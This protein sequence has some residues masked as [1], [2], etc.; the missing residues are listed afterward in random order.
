MQ[1]E[2]KEFAIRDLKPGMYISQVLEQSGKLKIRT[3]GLV[4]TDKAIA[5]LSDQGVIKVLVDLSKS[6]L[7]KKAESEEKSKP[8][9]AP[10]EE[11]P[12][13]PAANSVSFE[14][15]INKASSLY[16]EAKQIQSK[17]FDSMKANAPIDSDSVKSA[18]NG[19][20]DSVFRN[21]DALACMTRMRVKD[22]YLMEHSINVAIIMTI[23]A[24]HLKLDLEVI[25]ELATGAMLMDLG[26]IGIPSAILSKKGALT[27][28]ERT[29]MEQHVNMGYKVLSKAQGLSSVSLELVQDHHEC[30]DGSGYPNG[31]TGEQLSLYAKMAKIVDCYDAITAD[32]SYQKAKTPVS[33]FKIL[34]SESGTSFDQELVNEFIKCMGIHPV[35]T[36]V[37]MKSNK[38]GIVVK[39]NPVNPISPSVNVFYSVGNKCYIEPKIIDLATPGCSDEIDKSVRPEEFKLDML[40]FFKQVLLN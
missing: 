11:K 25:Q 34:R 10:V 27:A 24:K 17:A 1:Q 37:K 32:R 38:L 19:L 40:K 14:K 29:T 30:I 4:S 18:A 33:A 16:Q 31:K 20:I 13:Q 23:F 26:M 35:G 2:L 39:S 6:K 5:K 21:Q 7:A 15:E 3:Q 8:A 28:D 22:E 12:K 9:E 36:L